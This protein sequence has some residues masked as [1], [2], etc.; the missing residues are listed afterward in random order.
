M[1]TLEQ[2]FDELEKYA[3]KSTPSASPELGIA[4]AA[5]AIL[6]D[7][8]KQ[9]RQQL[10]HA[11]LSA[12]ARHLGGVVSFE[13]LQL[14]AVRHLYEAEPDVQ[15]FY[16]K[17]EPVLRVTTV[18]RDTKVDPADEQVFPATYLVHGPGYRLKYLGKNKEAQ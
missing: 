15:V 5:Q 3:P 11:I 2:I 13:E 1:L 6:Q 4:S 16:W 9:A 17:D 7:L 18:Y 8:A 14:H 10:D 12:F